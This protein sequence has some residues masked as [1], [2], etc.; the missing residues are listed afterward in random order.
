M[1]EGYLHAY[2]G[3]TEGAEFT[4]T[5]G[6]SSCCAPPII[7]YEGDLIASALASEPVGQTG[8]TSLLTINYKAPDYAGHIYNMLNPHEEAALREVDAQL[9]RLVADLDAR[10]PGEYVLIVTADHGQCPLVND[11][12]GVRLDPTQ[13]ANDIE[14]RFGQLVPAVQSVRPAEIYLKQ[15]A[16]RN[17]AGVADAI[18]AWLRTY[19]YGDNV[20][21]YPGVPRAAIQ[22]GDMRHLEFAAALSDVY[23][24]RMGTA[25]TM[26]AGYGEGV[27]GAMTD[28]PIPI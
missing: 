23:L 4:P 10:F 18:A 20:Y 5:R 7:Q 26:A 9:G 2:T 3:P 13:L 19:T 12:G 24:N 22:W 11:A 14:Q 21:Q 6:A 15:E 28:T 17:D 16:I 1:L 25:A 8:A 27:Y